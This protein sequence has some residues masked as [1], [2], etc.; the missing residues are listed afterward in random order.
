MS[1]PWRT[2]TRFEAT[3]TTYEPCGCGPLRRKFTNS[4]YVMLR[5]KLL[6]NTKEYFRRYFPDNGSAPKTSLGKMIGLKPGETVL[7]RYN[8]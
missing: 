3:Q 7:D 5:S 6:F 1:S 8:T 2:W 4:Q